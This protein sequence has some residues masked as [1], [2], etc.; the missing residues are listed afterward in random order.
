MN[1]IK[2]KWSSIKAD[3]KTVKRFGLIL[4]LILTVLGVIAFLRGHHQ[5]KFEW[6]LAAASLI[7][8]LA[9]PGLLVYIYRPWM[10]VA[11][12]ISWV[13][14]R[15]I[16]GVFFYLVLTP[17]NLVMKLLKKDILDQKIDRQ[18]TTHWKKRTGFST[19]ERYEKLF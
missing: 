10:M 4:S 7:L 12:V 11:E 15:L 2:H 14:L 16:L 9:A 18:A 3:T 13:V 8:S 17:V 5:Y 1:W 6:P 19:Q